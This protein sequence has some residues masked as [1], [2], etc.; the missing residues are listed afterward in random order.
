MSAAAKSAPA[1]NAPS[2]IAIPR[3]GDGEE[4]LFS[5]SR[6]TI[7]DAPSML[8][9]GDLLAF[10]ARAGR[11]VSGVPQV[12][13]GHFYFARIGV[14][15]LN[16]EKESGVLQ[17][18]AGE[19]LNSAIGNIA[20]S[21]VRA[22][23]G[24]KFDMARACK[25][26]QTFVLPSPTIVATRL[27]APSASAEPAVLIVTGEDDSGVTGEYRAEFKAREPEILANLLWVNRFLFELGQVH[28]AILAKPLDG[29]LADRLQ[30]VHLKLLFADSPIG[31]EVRDKLYALVPEVRE[32]FPPDM[33]EWTLRLAFYRLR[34]FRRIPFFET[35]YEPFWSMLAH[36]DALCIACGAPNAADAAICAKCGKP[37]Y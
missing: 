24:S 18:A 31:S 30:Q 7:L 1:E 25:S 2:C 17:E 33:W 10:P 28:D 22:F 26:P 3:T 19:L 9:A 8:G 32:K 27:I 29:A 6:E 5:F 13:G 34:R 11:I 37:M 20:G 12:A 15:F 21:A 4:K 35:T 36:E 14:A 23:A 16:T